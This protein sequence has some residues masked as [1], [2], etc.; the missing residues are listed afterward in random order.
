[1]DK[2]LFYDQQST[3]NYP[4]H[5]YDG[6]GTEESSIVSQENTIDTR[7]S[8][9]FNTLDVAEMT[10]VQHHQIN[11]ILDLSNQQHSIPASNTQYD[12]LQ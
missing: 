11:M 4:Q 7:V 8:H 1:M 2:D 6:L 9:K 10:T 3:V 5:I 12:Q